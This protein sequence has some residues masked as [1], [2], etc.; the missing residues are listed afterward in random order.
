MKAVTVSR[1]Q[2]PPLRLLK[3]ICPMSLSPMK[4]TVQVMKA[5][6][7]MKMMIVDKGGIMS[8][9][10][11]GLRQYNIVLVNTVVLEDVPMEL[12][13]IMSNQLNLRVFIRSRNLS[14]GK[15]ATTHISFIAD[16]EA[17][18]LYK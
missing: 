8:H 7:V 1:G 9:F 5:R 14:R 13:G 3:R 18:N 4:V 16:L 12:R 6:M 17:V 2:S 15:L 10:Y 11:S